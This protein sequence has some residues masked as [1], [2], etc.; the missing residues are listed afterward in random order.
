MKISYISSKKND[1]KRQ[2]C[3]SFIQQKFTEHFDVED[4]VNKRDSMDVAVYWF[5]G[6]GRH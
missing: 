6:G 5:S 3:I 2:R 4:L 1:E